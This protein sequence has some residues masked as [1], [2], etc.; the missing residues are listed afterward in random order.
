M[1]RLKNVMLTA[2]VLAIPAFA[3]AKLKATEMKT[4]RTAASKPVAFNGFGVVQEFT[5]NFESVAKNY[6]T[7]SK[8]FRDQKI[9]GKAGEPALLILLEDPTGKSEF[10]YVLGY[11]VDGKREP[12]AP[13]ELRE[14]Q[15]PQA[16]R[17][18]HVGEYSELEEVHTEVRSALKEASTLKG[19]STQ[20]ETKFPVVLRL[21]ND[22]R[23][24]A[25]AQRKTEMIVPVG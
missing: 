8:E 3:H 21:L 13:L 1:K 16:V 25:P 19:A 9:E 4:I 6:D 5:G 24:V 20:R 10:R 23:K 7:F 12:K 15:H 11:T 14:M 22:P 17:V 2:L 18:T